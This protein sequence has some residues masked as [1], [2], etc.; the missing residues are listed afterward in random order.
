MAQPEVEN[1]LIF[2]GTR[3]FGRALAIDLR[4]KGV[5]NLALGTSD[6]KNGHFRNAM[7]EFTKAGLETDGIVPFEAELADTARIETQIENLGFRPGHI[8]MFP[9]TGMQFAMEFSPYV[10]RLQSIKHHPERFGEN[11]REATLDELHVGY[12]VWLPR[13]LRES[14]I[15][16]VEAPVQAIEVLSAHLPEGFT[17]NYLDSLFADEG[18]GPRCYTDVLTKH[19]F[20]IWLAQ[21]ARSYARRGIDTSNIKTAAIL[22]TEIGDFLVDEISEV[23]NEEVAEMLIDTA[24]EPQDVFGAY[25][26]F[27][28][29]S[30]AERAETGLPFEQYVYRHSGDLIVAQTF[31]DSLRIDPNKYLL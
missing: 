6:L 2:G 21:N 27:M 16:N 17:L 20:G 8:F 1:V 29:M 19:M 18:R 14:L 23:E 7:V 26:Q 5:T 25:Y 10:T 30:R 12:D 13:Y 4:R 22:G 3:G 15:M 9:A 28:A 31:P 24:V 11:A